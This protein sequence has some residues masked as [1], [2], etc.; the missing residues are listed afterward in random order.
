MSAG[1]LLAAAALLPARSTAVTPH[2]EASGGVAGSGLTI[3]VIYDNVP[4]DESLVPDWGFSA[5]IEPEGGPRILFDTGT[6]GEILLSN[7][8][9]LG[10]DPDS[11]DMVVISHAHYDHAGGL[12]D[13]LASISGSPLLV[14]CR[15][16]PGQMRQL[17][18]DDGCSLLEAG[19][20]PLELA[21]GVRSTGEMGGTIRE[22]G[23]LV[24]FG[25]G[26]H[27]L[28]TGCAHPG[29]VDMAARALEMVGS[30][31]SLDLVMGGFHL[32]DLDQ[33]SAAETAE[34]LREMGAL[35]VAASHCTGEAAREA[36][37]TVYGEACYP[38]GTGWRI[39]LPSA[40]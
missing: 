22:Q 3:T 13:L 6:S 30:R 4:L 24:G 26:Q 28:L 9:V 7:M 16:F 11:L 21:P 1:A 8:R 25:Q 18:M 27:V 5:L 12:A 34:K 14:L 31:G 17:G 36:F 20:E 19:E 32:R 2:A 38:G 35:A 33:A 40:D 29:I 37:A 39:H 23:L 10:I 15:S